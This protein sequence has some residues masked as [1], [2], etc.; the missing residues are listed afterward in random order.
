MVT[1]SALIPLILFI[2]FGVGVVAVLLAVLRAASNRR[3]RSDVVKEEPSGQADNQSDK[4]E[5]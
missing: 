4:K 1:L 5:E 3:M 2:L